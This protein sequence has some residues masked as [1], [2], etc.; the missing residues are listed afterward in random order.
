MKQGYR[1]IAL[2]IKNT[3][4]SVKNPDQLLMGIEYKSILEAV[5]SEIYTMLSAK[6]KDKL[7]SK[8]P[9]ELELMMEVIQDA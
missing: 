3:V 4:K 9:K 5:F 2:L 8:L 6:A 1:A 7:W